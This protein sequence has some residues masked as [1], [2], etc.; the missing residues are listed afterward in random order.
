MRRTGTTD[1]G[2]GFQG[3]AL[4]KDTGL[5]YLRAR[6]YNPDLGRF[7][8]M[9]SYEGDQVDPQSLN[10]YTAF[11]NDPN[12]K[13]DPSGNQ[14]GSRQGE[15]LRGIPSLQQ[16]EDI[17]G[18]HLSDKGRD[19]LKAREGYEPI[20]KDDGFNNLTVAWGHKVFPQEANAYWN[21]SKIKTPDDENLLTND[22]HIDEKD[23][24]SIV[25]VQMFQYEFDA[26]ISFSFQ[27][28]KGRGNWRIFT[29]INAMQYG[30]VPPLFSNYTVV[31]K[32][33]NPGIANRRAL[34]AQL[35]KSGTY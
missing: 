29:T 25:T 22:V 33:K 28:I 8:Q 7:M 26:M 24:K 20:A 15:L 2:V 16:R 27:G 34:E 18:L 14:Y 19:F 21:K 1:L 13:S 35:F 32:K 6:W 23:F 30:N 11:A 17:L 4:D 9:D 12:D 3:E 31:N 10:K 5:I